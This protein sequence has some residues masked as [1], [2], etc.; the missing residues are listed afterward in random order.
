M[1]YEELAEQLLLSGKP[2]NQV[3]STLVE[4]GTDV[5]TAGELVQRLRRKWHHISSSPAAEQSGAYRGSQLAWKL[6]LD[7]CSDDEI[8]L[9]LVAEVTDCKT[10]EEL[11]RTLRRVA[12]QTSGSQVA[13][14]VESRA[15]ARRRDKRLQRLLL[16]QVQ[17]GRAPQGLSEYSE[18]QQLYNKGLLVEEH[19]AEGRVLKDGSGRLRAVIITGLTPRG[20]DF[21]DEANDASVADARSPAPAPSAREAPSSETLDASES[22]KLVFVSHSSADADLA[23]AVVDLLCAALGLRRSDFL[24]TSV[25]GAKLAGGD[26]TDD[27]LRRQIRDARCFISLLTQKAVSSTY[28]LFELGA[29]WGFGKHHIPLLAKGAGT[30]VLREPLKARIALDLGREEGVHA[31]VHGLGKLLG[32]QPESPD[33]YLQRVREVVRISAPPAPSGPSPA[34]SPPTIERLAGDRLKQCVDLIKRRGPSGFDWALSEI[35]KVQSTLAIDKEQIT[36]ISSD[37]VLLHLLPDCQG[38]PATRLW[39]DQQNQSNY[40]QMQALGNGSTVKVIQGYKGRLT[41][42]AFETLHHPECMVVAEAHCEEG[43]G[44]P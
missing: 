18:D 3:I 2:Y 21:I 24:C 38:K 5:I 34:V 17:D 13:K 40:P 15:M 42:I 41:A 28:V 11:V 16:V 30:E 36:V 19:L 44:N 29:R 26:V 22:E 10:A 20:H 4:R 43:A 32:Y 25:D 9:R 14:R 8:V 31:L 6:M 37:T 12:E 27:S 7:G 23:G 33:S 39:V 1:E 35:R